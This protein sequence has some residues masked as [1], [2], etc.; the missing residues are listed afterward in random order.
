MRRVEII[1]SLFLMM[2]LLGCVEKEDKTNVI[3]VDV[4]TTYPKKEL[5]LQDLM[6]VEYIPLETNDEFITQG[7]VM[8]IG[9]KYILVKNWSHDGNIFVFDRKTGKGIR[10]IN[11]KGQGDGEYSFIN[12]II[13]D[14]DNNEMFVNCASTKKIYVYDLSGNFKRDFKH[15]EG[16]EY[17]EVFN[18]DKN[19]LICYDMSLYY[20]EGQPREENRSY[21]LIISKQ[22]GSVTQKIYIPFDV[23]KTPVVQKGGATSIRSIIPYRKE[24]LLVETS[25]DTVYNY[26]PE[27]NQLNPF[28]IKSPTRDLEI[29]LTMGVVTDRYCFMHTV[30]KDFDFTTGR[31]FLITDL[32]YDKQEN[33]VF[34][35]NV[36]NGDFVEKQ[37]VDMLSD[38]MNG[39]E[40]VAIQPLAANKIVDAYKNDGLKGKLK[41]IAAGLDEESNPVIMLVKNRE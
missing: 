22:D 20:K 9:E 35:A 15:V 6:D 28:L 27:K 29:L 24:W 30:K 5:V 41:E 11:R 38:P 2:G 7:S 31:G 16:G 8:A 33:A 34:E 23:I 3:T 19:N 40:I 36:L 4:T 14:E 26:V 12:G 32:M 37:N 25:S 17:L 13:L 21:H 39:D 18:Y 10:K 1:M